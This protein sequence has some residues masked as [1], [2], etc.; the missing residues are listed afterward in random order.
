MR[1]AKKLGGSMVISGSRGPGYLKGQAL[2]A[3]VREFVEKMKPHVATAEQMGITIGIENHANSLIDST[4][5]IRWLAEFTPCRYFGIAL[6]PYHLPQDP[7]LIAKLITDIGNCV[8]HFYAW[9][10][11]QGCHKKLPKQQELMQLPG[12]GEM[13]FVPI[14]AALK[15]ISYSGWT[16]V[17]MHPVPR[18]I[19]ILPTA[20]AHSDDEEGRLQAAEDSK[21]S[22]VISWLFVV[23]LQGFL[24]I[25]LYSYG[26]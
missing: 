22:S 12:R 7:V 17:F 1:I 19:S 15:K 24:V 21:R 23:F 11:G 4:D 13:D 18:R 25:Y 8:V 10:Y 16:D 20:R 3:T 5:A 9:Q 2:K 26:P 14:V 6:T